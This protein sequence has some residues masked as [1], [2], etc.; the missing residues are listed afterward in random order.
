VAHGAVV[1][2]QGD[3]REKVGL[4]LRLQGGHHQRMITLVQRSAVLCLAGLRCGCVARTGRSSFRCFRRLDVLQQPLLERAHQL[5]VLGSR[6]QLAC[7]RQLLGHGRERVEQTGRRCSRCSPALALDC[8]VHLLLLLLRLLA[9]A[10][11]A[12]TT[13]QENRVQL[14]GVLVLVRARLGVGQVERRDEVLALR[15]VQRLRVVYR[16]LIHLAQL[17][18]HHAEVAVPGGEL[19]RALH[20]EA[21]LVER[22]RRGAVGEED[23]GAIVVRLEV[24]TVRGE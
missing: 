5:G 13:S 14:R 3:Q 19:R 7:W 18:E 22:G 11:D 21:E 10:H 9:V 2:G 6:G 8:R 12:P 24:S 4:F 15:E 17:L 20:H 16:S 1:Q 23:Q